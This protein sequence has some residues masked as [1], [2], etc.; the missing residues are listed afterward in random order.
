M[1]VSRAPFRM[2]LAGG[3]T[4]IKSFYEKDYGSVVSLTIDKYFYIILHKSFSDNYILHYSKTEITDE[5]DKIKNP[6]FR[7]C[8]RKVGIK[9]KLEI[10]SIA[11]VPNGTGL[12]SS[13]SLTCALLKALYK[14]KGVDVDNFEIASLAC[15]IEID[16]LGSPIGKQDQ[17]AAALGGFNYYIFKSNGDVNVKKIKLSK[18]ELNKLNDNLILLWTGLT[19]SANKILSKQ[20]Q[21][22]DLIYD[23][24][25][26]IRKYSDDLYK[27]LKAGKS[28]NLIGNTLYKVWEEKVKL[29]NSI[30]NEVINNEYK[31]AIKNGAKGGKILGAGGGGFLLLYADKKSQKKIIKDAS[32]DEFKF[33]LTFKGTEIIFQNL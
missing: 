26:R 12:G 18:N 9:D 1:I 31:K 27:N 33:N 29:S 21:N 15:E 11:D 30:S 7:E 19:R 4:D 8:I 14:Y 2:S 22:K 10:T 16:I 5:L 23:N 3:A 24:L 17:F 13:S 32:F 25:L 28:I 20:N 6:I